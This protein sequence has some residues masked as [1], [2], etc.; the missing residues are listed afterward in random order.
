MHRQSQ[1][2]GLS[3]AGRTKAGRK[4]RTE[5]REDREERHQEQEKGQERL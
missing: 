2:L 1:G 5:E 4:D 3:K